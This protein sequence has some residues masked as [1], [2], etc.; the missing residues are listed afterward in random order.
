MESKIR[1]IQIFSGAEK[2]KGT[3]AVKFSKQCRL[4]LKRSKKTK[5]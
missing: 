4:E 3:S 1:M 2:K 5:V